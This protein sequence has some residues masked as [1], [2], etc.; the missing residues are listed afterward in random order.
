MRLLHTRSLQFEEF[1]D[2]E[3]PR[4]AILSHRWEKKEVSFQEFEQ[5]KEEAWPALSKIR[6]FCQLAASQGFEWGWV[7]TCC[8]DKKSSAELSEAIN[9]MYRWYANAGEC[10]AYLSDVQA[11]KD[12][13][14]LKV[15]F[16]KS[17]WFTRGWTL[18]E[19]LAP[20]TVSFF[21]CE[22]N[23]IGDKMGLSKEISAAT[24][25]QSQHPNDIKYACV[26]V[27]M[28]WISRRQTSR[29]E[30]MA[31][32]LLGIF[33]V[34]MPLLYGEGRKAFIRLE[35]EILKKS[36]DESIFAWTSETLYPGL[37]AEWPD[38]FASSAD[39]VLARFCDRPP[40][41]MTNRGLKIYVHEH[42]LPIIRLNCVKRVKDQIFSI[43]LRLMDFNRFWFRVDQ[44]WYLSEITEIETLLKPEW[45]KIY[46]NRFGL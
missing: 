22:W 3:I 45:Q 13:A 10:Y 36:N 16:A 11:G 28:S 12:L 25:I 7:D 19:L 8:I 44:E 24:G 1:F 6:N 42:D 2:S 15:S 34:N 17:A 43:K 14:D 32:C 20:H 26:A 29:V 41:S 21:D 9:S 18:Q 30:D 46:V 4:Y 35:L 23:Y 39:I 27:K 37:L 31:Y 33:D 40:Y 5:A 38:V